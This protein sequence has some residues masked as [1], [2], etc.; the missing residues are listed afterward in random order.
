MFLHI[1]NLT[2]F[3]RGLPCLLPMSDVPLVY[4]LMDFIPFLCLYLTVY[5][6]L[7]LIVSSLAHPFLFI[8][9]PLLYL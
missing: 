2:G 6:C 7:P 9:A 8:V 3:A 1:G 4:C 5:Y